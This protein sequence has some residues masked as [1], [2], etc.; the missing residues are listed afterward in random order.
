MDDGFFSN[1]QQS[2]K[3]MHINRELERLTVM[4]RDNDNELRKM[5]SMQERFVINYQNNMNIMG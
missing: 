5:Q 1:N 4:T 2:E 3:A